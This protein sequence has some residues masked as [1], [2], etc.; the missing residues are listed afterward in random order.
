M[1]NAAIETL[2]V[3]ECDLVGTIESYTQEVKLLSERLERTKTGL[4]NSKKD[5]KD[6]QDALALLKQ[7][8]FYGV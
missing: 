8:E 7:A 1:H 2:K 6:V 4:F 5:L 3:R